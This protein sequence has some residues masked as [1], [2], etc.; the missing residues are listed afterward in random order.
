LQKGE[1][2][3]I[4]L[5]D[6]DLHSAIPFPAQRATGVVWLPSDVL[7]DHILPQRDLICKQFKRPGWL[8]ARTEVLSGRLWAH[9]DPAKMKKFLAVV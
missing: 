3:F 6:E 2:R 4:I 7:T 8:L 1:D 5:D 9:L